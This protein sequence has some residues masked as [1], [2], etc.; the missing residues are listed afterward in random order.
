MCCLYWCFFLILYVKMCI[1]GIFLLCSHWSSL[2]RDK[3]TS[4]TQSDSIRVKRRLVSNTRFKGKKTCTRLVLGLFINLVIWPDAEH[5]KLLSQYQSIF[6]YNRY[7]FN[8]CLLIF[9]CRGTRPLIK[10]VL[11]LHV[12]TRGVHLVMFTWNMYTL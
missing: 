5:F 4:R 9:L 7:W 8:N 12:S 6:F 1:N 3:V 2:V 11:N 10:S